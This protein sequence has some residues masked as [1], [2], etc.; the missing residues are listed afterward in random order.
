MTR[1]E[2]SNFL[3]FAAILSGLLGVVNLLRPKKRWL[4]AG[5]VLLGVATM[6]YR[7]NDLAPTTVV[8]YVLAI[9]CVVRDGA[10]RV[11]RRA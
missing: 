1:E 2:F 8:V 6:L 5:A 11:G 3:L 7:Q 10:S 9:L 4:G